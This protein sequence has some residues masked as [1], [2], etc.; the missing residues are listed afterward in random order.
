[1][2]SEKQASPLR[3]VLT[4][5]IIP[6]LLAVLP[7]LVFKKFIERPEKDIGNLQ[8]KQEQ[9]LTDLKQVK[10]LS[11]DKI[12]GFRARAAGLT[13]WA[14]KYPDDQQSKVNK[15]EIDRQLK[16]LDRQLT[17]L[18]AGSLSK[19][20]RKMIHEATVIFYN[21]A[22]EPD[23]FVDSKPTPP[24]PYS[25]GIAHFQLVSGTH[26]IRAEYS[27]RVCNVTLVVPSDGPVAANCELK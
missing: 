10:E 23:F 18:N 21:G 5:L 25:S 24:P 4:I 20:G 3:T 2:P 8:A 11:S 16:Q 6:L 7:T 27:N 26:R 1:M 19:S 9:L 17:Q 13:S 22:S 14:A 15:D 12:Q